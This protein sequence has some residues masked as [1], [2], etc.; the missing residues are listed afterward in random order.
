MASAQTT[1]LIRVFVDSSVLFAAALSKRGHARELL[2]RGLQGDVELVFSDLVFEETARN[3][4]EKAPQ[5]LPLF[6]LVREAL[7]RSVVHALKALVLKAARVVAVKDAPILAAAAEARASYLATYDE[8]HLL[9]AAHLIEET[10]GLTVARPDIVLR[11][12]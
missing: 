4:A 11:E 10:F 2:M 5:A 8:K 3:L 9:R 7:G 12:L 1:S 6:A